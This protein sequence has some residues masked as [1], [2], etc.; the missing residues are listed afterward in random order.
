MMQFYGMCFHY[1]IYVEGVF[2]E[3]LRVLFL[4]I[5]SVNGESTSLEDIDKLDL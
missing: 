4:L 5:S 1:A 3:A 2:D